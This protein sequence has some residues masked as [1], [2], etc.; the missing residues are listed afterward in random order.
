M[1]VRESEL[2]FCCHLIEFV[3]KVSYE[4]KNYIKK[5]VSDSYN[6]HEFLYE[7]NALNA[8]NDF[9]H[10][11]QLKTFMINDSRTIMKSLLIEFA[12]RDALINL[13]YDHKGKIS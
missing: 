11:I 5:E 12:Q 8:L 1:T 3:Y 9:D 4:D 2:E 6:V 7:T 13:L 10:I